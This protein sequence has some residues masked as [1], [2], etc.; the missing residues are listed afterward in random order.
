MQLETRMASNEE[1]IAWVKILENI[2]TAIE[3]KTETAMRGT[4]NTSLA[5]CLHLL[6]RTISVSGK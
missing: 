5:Q 6:L 3:H 1:A 4:L 2:V